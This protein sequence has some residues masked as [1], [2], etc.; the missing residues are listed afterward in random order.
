MS[1]GGAP[2]GSARG[3]G[4]GDAQTL[5]VALLLVAL[6]VGTLLSRAGSDGPAFQTP[7]RVEVGPVEDLRPPAEAAHAIAAGQQPTPPAALDLNAVDVQALQTLPGVGPVLAERI[8]AY[9]R[10]HGPFRAAEE[11]LQVPGVGPQRWGRLRGLVR[12][13]EGA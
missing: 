12:V 4:P 8:V 9:R 6:T 2:G 7:P 5:A 1:P 11:L 10:V 3:T 13:G